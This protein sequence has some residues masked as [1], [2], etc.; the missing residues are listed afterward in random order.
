LTITYD[1]FGDIYTIHAAG[2]E[3]LIRMLVKVR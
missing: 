2:G 3:G 1:E